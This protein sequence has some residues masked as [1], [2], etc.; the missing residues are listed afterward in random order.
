MSKNLFRVS[1]KAR[2]LS[3]FPRQNIT[4]VLFLTRNQSTDSYKAPAK[5][6]NPAYDVALEYL[7]QYSQARL[8]KVKDIEKQLSSPTLSND[9]K[10]DLEQKR[11]DLLVESKIHMP[12]TEWN[13]KNNTYDSEEPV[14]HYLL[15][16]QW[17]K[18]Q[19]PILE[20]RTT[21]MFIKPDVIPPDSS[22]DAQIIIKYPQD[23]ETCNI[24]PGVCVSP[25]LVKVCPQIEVKV[26]HKDTRLYTLV[27]VDPDCPA[28]EIKN[29]REK[30]HWAVCNIPISFSSGVVD[31][32][33]A[34]DL[35]IPYLPPHPQKGSSKHRFTFTLL[36][37]PNS[38][39][40]KLNPET[41]KSTL[42][43]PTSCIRSLINTMDL[44][45][46]GV[47]FFRSEWSSFVTSFY[48]DVLNLPEPTFGPTPTV[49][50]RVGPDG[51]VR[52][53]YLNA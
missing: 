2:A 14:F 25:E 6:V 9:H 8:D 23:S 51:R 10:L 24:F 36:E 44:T 16:Q 33:K 37:Q 49:S 46:S 5:N 13:F 47:H 12:S 28:P 21:Q 42:L 40:T 43:E 30:T 38:G 45:V 17:D 22:L 1:L 50:P 29:Y 26:F 48:K 53:R 31:L 19:R 39:S 34:G 11:Y 20:Q 27:F 52:N 35:V 15:S 18:E 41:L 4:S 32:S 3:C 7:E